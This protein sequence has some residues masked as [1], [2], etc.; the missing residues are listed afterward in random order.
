MKKFL[1]NTF[2]IVLSTS[3]V[4]AAK[5][6]A[7]TATTEVM[8]SSSITHTE[9]SMEDDY[10]EKRKV[11]ERGYQQGL[12]LFA[13]DRLNLLA[14]N[15]SE[16]MSVDLNKSLNIL[17]EKYPHLRQRSNLEVLKQLIVVLNDEVLLAD[18]LAFDVNKSAK[19]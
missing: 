14:A 17:R 2:L 6:S 3:S 7:T 12:E 11:L 15:N 13:D 19:N 10:C 18:V 1:L 8:S 4:Y 5:R 16:N 9:C